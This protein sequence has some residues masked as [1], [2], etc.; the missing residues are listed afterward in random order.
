MG[1]SSSLFNFICFGTYSVLLQWITI[2][3]NCLTLRALLHRSSFN[4]CRCIPDRIGI[5]QCW[6]LWRRENRS[7]RRK[8]SRS[9]ERTNNKHMTRERESNP[10]HIGGRRALSPLRYPCS[11]IMMTKKLMTFFGQVLT[12]STRK[13]S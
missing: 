10:G 4:M 1:F 13:Q 6:F 9:M 3:N 7:T 11:P 5:W 12:S 2:F 8:T